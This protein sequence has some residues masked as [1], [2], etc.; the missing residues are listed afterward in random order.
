MFVS[1]KVKKGIPYYYLVKTGRV[2]GRVRVVWQMYL[3]SA[4][5]M[6]AIFEKEAALVIQSKS[7]GSIAS[8]LSVADDL[9]L[10]GIIQRAVPRINLKHSVTQHI[11]MQS[12]CPFP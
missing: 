11:I 7:F 2:N 10:G 6:K 3:G 4:E 9:D 12:I 1:K 5:R 8:M